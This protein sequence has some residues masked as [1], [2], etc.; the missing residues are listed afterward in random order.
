MDFD[1]SSV[2]VGMYYQDS[3]KH[4]CQ[5]CGWLIKN[6]F[7]LQKRTVDGKKNW[8]NQNFLHLYQFL[9]VKIKSK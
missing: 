8:D 7:Y 1:L 5:F 2:L 4:Q 9:I 6:V 3:I